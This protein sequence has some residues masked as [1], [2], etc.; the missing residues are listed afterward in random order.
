MGDDRPIVDTPI[1][2]LRAGD[3]VV[4][5]GVECTVREVTN[6]GTHKDAL[7]VR[8]RGRPPLHLRWDAKLPRKT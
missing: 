1:S 6:E 5:D 3:I 4:V 2:E 8:L 7:F